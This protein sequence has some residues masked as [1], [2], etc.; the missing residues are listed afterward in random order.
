MVNSSGRMVLMYATGMGGQT[1]PSPDT[2]RTSGA[3]AS[4]SHV[5]AAVCFTLATMY[6]YREDTV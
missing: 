6:T 2:T 5:S 1:G 4:L 3:V